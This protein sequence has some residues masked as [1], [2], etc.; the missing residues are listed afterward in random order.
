MRIY[1]AGQVTGKDYKTAIKE[2][3]DAEKMLE[4][5]GDEVVN[6]TRYCD[7]SWSWEKCMRVCLP[8]LTE[9]DGIYMLRDWKKSRGAK[10][11]HF[12]AIKL[13]MKIENQK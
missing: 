1:I 3:D 7:I 2:F 13:G 8:L 12:V 10:L 9:C 11:E 6:P 5:R 4:A